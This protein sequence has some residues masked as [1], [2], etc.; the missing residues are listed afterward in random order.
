MCGISGFLSKSN[1]AIL[2]ERDFNIF[3]NTL[4][5]RGP[6][7]SGVYSDVE[8]KLFLGHRRLSILDL[9][10]N[11]NQPYISED[12]NYVLVFNGEIFNFLEI[13]EKLVNRGVHF[14]SE[15]DTEVLLKLLIHFGT[16]GLHELNG[17]WA[18]ALWN[19]K[20]R[21][22]ILCRDRYGIKPLFF[23]NT[24]D[25]FAF[26]SET[27]SFKHL[28]GW[29]RTINPQ[30]VSFQL[31]NFASLE[32]RGETLF[33][34]IYQVQPG[35]LLVIQDKLVGSQIK[36]WNTTD[37]IRPYLH[38]FDQAVNEFTE[39]LTDSIKIRLRSDVPIATALSGGLDSSSVY[40]IIRYLFRN[41]KSIERLPSN[42]QQ[43][44]TVSFPNTSLDEID[45]AKIVV[46]NT[47]LHNIII[48]DIKNLPHELTKS[49]TKFDNFY[50]TPIE[51]ISMV[52]KSMSDNGFKVSLDGH[53][54]DELM[55]GY[56]SQIKECINIA[57]RISN[58][59]NFY[60]FRDIYAGFELSDGLDVCNYRNDISGRLKSALR[61]SK[62]LSKLLV[63]RNR[64][65]WSKSVQWDPWLKPEFHESYSRY[66]NFQSDDIDDPYLNLLY[67]DFHSGLLPVLLRNFDRA[68]M[69]Y[70][71]EIRMPFLDHRIV[72]FIYSLPADYLAGSGFTKRLLRS[73]MEG[74]LDDRIRLNKR[75]MSLQAPLNYWMNDLKEMFLDEFNS[76]H[77]LNSDIW[78]GHLIKNETEKIY[79]DNNFFPTQDTPSKI[80]T[81]YNASI[82]INN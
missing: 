75:K 26:S 45:N 70:G 80:W 47:D 25:F 7:G 9:S 81:Y 5:H 34:N 32:S 6:D 69:N 33:N 27:I 40:S 44:F 61:K 59:D 68:S 28:K 74:K 52:Y 41:E 42:W 37:Y 63:K 50:L 30:N 64:L 8:A 43:A 48:P 56:T 65:N 57:Q 54:V 60:T 13:R 35:C 31:N 4:K 73:S 11:A 21:K 24:N 15:S 79:Y 62:L 1:N 12:K 77:F 71:V 19:K 20:D 38:S 82:I 23:S 78:D 2:S 72:N 46:A 39:L 17:M 3:N 49:L 51:V 66:S 14:S 16:D 36:W 55:F 10:E 53:G 58:Q 29:V 18:F 76:V 22:L 67:N